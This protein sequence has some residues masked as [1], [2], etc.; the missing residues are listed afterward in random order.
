M[1]ESDPLPNYVCMECWKKVE[2]FDEFHTS[3]Q[4]AQARYLSDLVKYEQETNHFV[5]VLEPVHLNIDTS[6]VEPID[7]FAN[8][9]LNEDSLIKDEYET[10]KSIFI[11]E[12]S[13]QIE[14]DLIE[15][16]ETPEEDFFEIKAIG[17][18]NVENET[19]KRDNTN[20]ILF[21]VI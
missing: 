15:N 14:N 8:D 9:E 4:T 7:V 19:G 16:E 11:D 18:T 1:I 10:C 6:N 17:Q 13:G 21:N 2:S 20:C 3:V 5:D 12:S